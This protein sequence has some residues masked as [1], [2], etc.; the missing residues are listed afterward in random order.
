MYGINEEGYFDAT[1]MTREFINIHKTTASC[2]IIQRDAIKLIKKYDFH[3]EDVEEFLDELYDS[4]PKIYKCINTITTKL[5]E[6][7]EYNSANSIYD[8]DGGEEN[9]HDCL[10]QIFSEL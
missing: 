4:S 9:F 5:Y 8:E 7:C 10:Q 1:E 6:L 3:R 2:K